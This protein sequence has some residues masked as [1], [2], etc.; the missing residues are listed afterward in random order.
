MIF[1]NNKNEK[2]LLISKVLFVVWFLLLL[3]NILTKDPLINILLFI[4]IGLA[5]FIPAFFLIFKNKGV[6]F[7]SFYV[8]FT[9]FLLIFCLLLQD[10][11]IT[12]YLFL[13]MGIAISFLYIDKHL[14]V[15]SSFLSFGI[16]TYF[17]FARREYI[18]P[19]NETF[20]FFYIGFS[21]ISLSLILYSIVSYIDKTHKILL[22]SKDE[23]EKQKLD[24]SKTFEKVQSSSKLFQK[25]N[26][27]LEQ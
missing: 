18:F 17:F 27:K 20:D 26:S 19:L 23:S 3:I 25:F 15:F 5:Y 2:N 24:L 9:T 16:G 1:L 8:L 10:S 14:L 13:Y 12:V 7:I 21:F 4:I 6:T 22:A 11:T